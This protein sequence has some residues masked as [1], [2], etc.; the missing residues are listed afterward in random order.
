MLKGTNVCSRL[1]VRFLQAYLSILHSLELL[2]LPESYGDQCLHLIIAL[3]K[4]DCGVALAV[5]SEAT[6]DD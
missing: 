1:M 6:L 3:P 5:L 2:V 4:V